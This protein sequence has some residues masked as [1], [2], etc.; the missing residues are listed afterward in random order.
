M[1]PRSPDEQV[2]HA[3]PPPPAPTA[4]DANPWPVSAQ[5]G[6]TRA[7]ARPARAPRSTPAPR[8][9]GQ[10]AGRRPRSLPWVPLLI[11]FAIAGAGVQEAI[12]ALEE[13][14]VAAAIGA[15][16]ILA[17]VAIFALRRILKNKE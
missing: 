8:T 17:V 5:A 13:G 16:V 14:D 12:R 11:L 15:L 4:R 7:E 2:R 3:L 10:R 9:P 1:K 6:G